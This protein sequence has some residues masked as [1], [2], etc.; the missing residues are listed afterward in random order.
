VLLDSLVIYP[1]GF[2]A[3]HVNLAAIYIENRKFDAGEFH[4]RL[5]TP[6][7]LAYVYIALTQAS[8]AHYEDALANAQ[9]AIEL[10]PEMIYAES[11]RLSV[12][13]AMGKTSEE[14]TRL[15]EKVS[16]HPRDRM[17]H[18]TLSMAYRIA[19]FKEGAEEHKKIAETLAREND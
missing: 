19:G 8:G 11:V 15:E 16:I 9:T 17:A 12:L 10:D 6:V 14:I 1:H 3:A 4:A 7:P 2:R 13:E 18:A 5:G